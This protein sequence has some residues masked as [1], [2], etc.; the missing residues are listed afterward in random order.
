MSQFVGGVSV[1]DRRD[2]RSAHS[3]AAIGRGISCGVA[4]YRFR[5]A[6]MQNGTI[7]RWVA[8]AGFAV[9]VTGLGLEGVAIYKTY[10]DGDF[11]RFERPSIGRLEPMAKFLFDRTG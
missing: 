4:P 9:L 3:R 2:K 10:D 1:R 11:T 7:S 5:R 8:L 6:A